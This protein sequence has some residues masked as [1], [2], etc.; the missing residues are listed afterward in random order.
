MLM[1]ERGVVSAPNMAI[2]RLIAERLELLL[3]TT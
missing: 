2:G 1:A 3:R